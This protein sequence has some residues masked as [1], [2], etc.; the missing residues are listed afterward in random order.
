MPTLWFAVLAGM[1]AVYV[2]LDGFDFGAGMLH[3]AVARDPEERRLV[4]RAIGPFWDGNEVWLLAA[5]GVLFL[6][7][8]PVYASALSG[9]YLPL[10]L[11]L[12]LLILRGIAIELRGQ[13]ALPMWWSFWDAVF[14]ASSAGLAFVLGAALGNVLRG[15]PLDGRGDFFVPFWT[16]F[17]PSPTPGALDWYT[18]LVGLLAVAAL[19]AHGGH[20]LALRTSGDLQARARRLARLWSLASLG[21]VAAALP[22]T[23]L[24]RPANLDGFR[25]GPWG[26][27]AFAV[28]ALG[29]GASF[30]AASHGRDALAFAG[31]CAFLAGLL[32]SAA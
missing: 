29:W 2:V 12:W 7:F 18:I 31:S 23:A 20:Y 3:L 8:P 22:A 13:L 32:A 30:W 5:G 1:L 21:L 17:Q 15:V 10:M 16:D 28:A 26:A 14:C 19:A 24:V 27:L 4:L 6:A 25:G 11:V 9:F